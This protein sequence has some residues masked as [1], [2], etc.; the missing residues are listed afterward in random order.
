MSGRACWSRASL[1]HEQ[2]HQ[3]AGQ[4]AGEDEGGEE[5]RFEDA[6]DGVEM[7]H[8]DVLNCDARSWGATIAAA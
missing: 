6:E 2:Y 4:Q 8:L 7:A 1:S 3:R 5:V